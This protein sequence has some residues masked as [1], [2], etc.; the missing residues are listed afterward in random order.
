[1]PQFKVPVTAETHDN[2]GQH[3]LAVLYHRMRLVQTR[4][5]NDVELHLYSDGSGVIG[6]DGTQRRFNSLELAAHLVG[7]LDEKGYMS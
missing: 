7:E 1:M 3:H 5:G 2:H 4:T 6:Y